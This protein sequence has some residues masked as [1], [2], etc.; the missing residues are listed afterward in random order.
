MH[1][2]AP[3]LR[4]VLLQAARPSLGN[5]RSSDG[6]HHNFRLVSRP[7]QP[8]FKFH[9]SRHSRYMAL[10]LKDTRMTDASC[11]ELSVHSKVET[12]L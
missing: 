6:S 7:I 2:R 5:R 8:R 12:H 9:D 10:V 1:S 4:R 3:V 11:E